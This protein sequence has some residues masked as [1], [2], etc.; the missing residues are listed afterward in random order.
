MKNK[1][2]I[3]AYWEWMNENRIKVSTKVYKT[4]EYI[5]KFLGDPESEW[6]YD[7]GKANHAISFI[8]KYCKHSK[9]KMGGKPF[10]LEL[11]QK[12]KVAA[13]FGIVHKITGERKYQRVVLIVARKNGKSTL[14]AAE[15]LY[16]FI[17]DGEPGAEIYSVATK[18]DQA[19]IIWLE[20]K[21]MVKK[22]PALSKRIKPLVAELTCEI[23]DGIYK[24]VGRDSDT[25]DGLNVHGAT[26][27][28][29]HAWT[30]KNLYDVIVDGTSARDQPLI[31]ITT[32][33]GTV[34]ENVYDDIY[35]EAERTINGYTDPDGYKD[36]R[37][38]FLVYELDDRKTWKDPET[39]TQANPGLG[40][41]K[42]TDAL[43]DKVNKAKANSKLVKNLLTKDFDIPE[44]TSEA[45]LTFE[46]IDNRAT[47][48]ISKLKPRYCVGGIDLSATTDLTCATIVFKLPDDEKTYVKQMYWLPGDL[49]ESRSQE[50]KIPYDVWEERGL[51]RRSGTNKVDYKDIT[52]WFL[53]VQNEMDCYIFKIGYDRW[54]ATYLVD[55]LTQYFGKTVPVP[56]AQGAK[57]FS[58]PMKRLES[59]LKAKKVNYNNNPITKWNLSNA[60][61][62]T[63]TNDNIALV[64]TSNHRRRIDGVASLMDALIVLED[65]LEEYLTLI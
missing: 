34:R 42:K 16:L 25:L 26:M 5:V 59:D 21:R 8:E 57:T 40:T 24:P 56:V 43:K 22:S 19:K 44:T 35:D 32:T 12:A 39:W 18:K 58:N 13:T 31:L 45:W 29:I 61:I 4:Y 46:T 37:S 50:D 49:I 55:E 23:N 64:K 3:E 38:L 62:K 27:D 63:D 48:D 53:E 65:N 11:W 2:P 15:G 36:E 1:N 52:K 54:S 47:Y 60:A 14:S 9:G 20:A 17:A 7:E 33:A 6:E 30:D 51:L 41:I 28:E 10:I